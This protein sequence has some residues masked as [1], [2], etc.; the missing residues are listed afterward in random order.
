MFPTYL[1]IIFHGMNNSVQVFHC[2]NTKTLEGNYDAINCFIILYLSTLQNAIRVCTVRE[3]CSFLKISPYNGCVYQCKRKLHRK[4]LDN[5]PSVH[6]KA[7]VTWPMEISAK[8]LLSI[9]MQYQQPS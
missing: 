5:V 6:L 8:I 7:N 9:P 4:N 2:N 1:F 3:R